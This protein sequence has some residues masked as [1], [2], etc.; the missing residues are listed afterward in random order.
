MLPKIMKWSS[1]AALVLAVLWPSSADYRIVAAVFVLWATT[2]LLLK[3][4]SRL[5]IASITDSIPRSESL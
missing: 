4:K 2:I 3:P 1:I 5:S